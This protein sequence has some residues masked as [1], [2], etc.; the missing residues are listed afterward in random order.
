MEKL[1]ITTAITNKLLKTKFFG[2][3]IVLRIEG[4][5]QTRGNFGEYKHVSLMVPDEKNL[6]IA[7]YRRN[8]LDIPYGNPFYSQSV[9]IKDTF[10]LQGIG[11]LLEH[12]YQTFSKDL[13]SAEKY[14][15]ECKS[16]SQSEHEYHCEVSGYIQ[17]K[18]N[19][20]IKIDYSL[21]ECKLILTWSFH[22]RRNPPITIR[23]YE[24]NVIDGMN[25]Q[26]SSENN[27]SNNSLQSQ[28]EFVG[29]KVLIKQY[30]VQHF[31]LEDNE[32]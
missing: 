5:E 22:E 12:F 10:T 2:T 27:T 4:V 30:F 8:N 23:F 6:C 25:G 9:I 29:K 16:S 20:D 1:A 26:I 28:G 15:K 13:S 3:D 21:R 7:G 17:C 31:R 14:I 18:V 19:I 11:I 32:Q 24:T